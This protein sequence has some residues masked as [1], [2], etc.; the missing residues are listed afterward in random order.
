MIPTDELEDYPKRT[1]ARR[2]VP[3]VLVAALLVGAIGYG[4]SRP[5]RRDVAEGQ[6]PR[7]SLEYL[8]GSGSLT[9]EDLEGHPVVVNFWASW[10]GPCREET[11]LLEEKWTAYRAEGVRFIG[12]VVRDTRESALD[13]VDEFDMTYDVLWD[14]DQTLAA[15]LGLVGN[16]GLPQTFFIGPDGHLVGRAQG[17]TIANEGR[18]AVLGAISEAELDEQIQ[19]ML[20]G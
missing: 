15:E 18:T 16:F 14:P 2:A 5:A 6:A 3:Y 10:C 19:A 8:D 20:D 1:S 13:F 11:P 12:V 4:L 7:F 17:D 9:S